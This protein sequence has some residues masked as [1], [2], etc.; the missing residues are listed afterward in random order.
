MLHAALSRGESERVA[1]LG[2]ACAGDL[3]LRREVEL[4]LAQQ[5]S[6]GGFLEDP[7]VATAAPMVS[8]TGSSVL[9]GRRLGVYQVHERIGVGGMGEV[10]RARDTKLG[11]DVALKV[12]PPDVSADR[13]R[14]ARF[15]R[16][17][18]TLASLNHP[19]IGA[20]YGFE[21]GVAG[22]GRAIRALVLELVEGETLAERIARAGA[23]RNTLRRRPSDGEAQGGSRPST[24][25]GHP[26]Q[27]EGRRR[28]TG[29]PVHEALTIAGQIADALD[30]AHEKGIIHR[31]LKPANIKV[32]PAGVVKVL[33]FGLAKDRR[34]VRCERAGHASSDR[35]ADGDRVGVILGTAAYMSPEQARGQVVDKR[36]DIWAFGCV[37]YELL[38]GR[39]AFARGTITD[40]LAAVVERDPEWN[41][42]P[43]AT[44][45]GIHRLLHRCLVKEARDRLRD[46]G[47]ARSEI[48]E[49]RSA[50]GPP[51]GARLLA[52][53]WR[54][55]AGGLALAAVAIGG[56]WSVFLPPPRSQSENQPGPATASFS[57][58]TAAPGIEWFPSLSPDGRWVVNRR[59]PGRNRDIDG[60]STTGQTPINLTKDS[61]EDDDQPAFSPDGERIAFRSNRDGGGIFIMGRTGEAVRRVT[62]NGFKPA[63]S[64][65]GRQLAYAHGKRRRESSEFRGSQRAVGG[66][67]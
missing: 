67:R 43:A 53:P 61:V 12:L 10:Y 37:L 47:D 19:H 27:A 35:H 34:S 40:T 25:S 57:Q 24:G 20:I 39:A 44:P 51:G 66:E 30:A 7:A 55:W 62:R 54:R 32:T 64:P 63:W 15:E 14:L 17:A 18:R 31:D 36:T 59:R 29:L 8:E 4:L 58:V 9:T 16:E 65:D 46:I 50:L 38:T 2:H 45:T 3:A 56:A 23:R 28:P 22:D 13:D 11:R 49:A 33:D 5:A 1:F 48:S 52:A 42:L 21:D 26:E 60:Q 6:M 41:A